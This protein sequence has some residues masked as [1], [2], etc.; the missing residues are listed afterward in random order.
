[1]AAL[2]DHSPE[3]IAAILAGEDNQKYR[4]MKFLTRVADSD[5][6]AV[7]EMYKT[8]GYAQL[9]RFIDE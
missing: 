6:D 5:Y 3:L 1:V 9:A 7:R 2:R 8:A 4:G